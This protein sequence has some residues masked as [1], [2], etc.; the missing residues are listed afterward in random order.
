MRPRLNERRPA[1]TDSAPPLA[2]NALASFFS[3]PLGSTPT[4]TPV[5]EL[6]NQLREAAEVSED[7]ESLPLIN[8]P[9]PTL[10]TRLCWGS[11]DRASAREIPKAPWSKESC[12]A[13]MNDPYAADGLALGVGVV[14]RAS[15]TSVFTVSARIDSDHNSDAVVMPPAT[16]K[17]QAAMVML[18]CSIVS[19]NCTRVA[20]SPSPGDASVNSVIVNSFKRKLA[21]D[22]S[23][24]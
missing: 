14:H 23:V 21:S 22:S 1:V 13:D 17:S 4:K 10:S 15:G 7:E 18:R 24:G 19:R 3:S 8:A 16:A 12:S 2:E 11:I 6:V 5:L 9:Y 20:C